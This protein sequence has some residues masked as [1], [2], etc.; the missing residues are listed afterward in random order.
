MQLHH[1]R[2]WLAGLALAACGALVAI[3]GDASA[4]HRLTVTASGGFTCHWDAAGN[5]LDGEAWGFDMFGTKFCEVGTD[6][7]TAMTRC[8][9]NVISHQALIVARQE[10]S[11]NFVQSYA[12]SALQTTWTSQSA[13][14]KYSYPAPG[15]CGGSGTVN[16]TAHSQGVETPGNPTP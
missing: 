13:V 10:P 11:N 5:Y 8:P 6:Q 4:D 9:A 1:R 14:A 16:W 7:G 15:F 12:Q 2:S 3:A